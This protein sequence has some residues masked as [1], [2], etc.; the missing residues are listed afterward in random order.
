MKKVFGYIRVSTVKQSSGVSLQEQK[1]A[2]I[3]YASK[4]Q[5]E[6]IEW[7]EEQETAA[8][9]G[10]PQFTKMMK[11]IRSGK[12]MG[13]IIHK[14]DRGARNLKD[15]GV[16]GDLIDEGYEIHFAHESL[17]MDTRGGRLAADIQ[18]VIASDYIR[19]LREETQKGINGRLKQGLYPFRAPIGYI[20]NGGG[21]VKTIDSI[22][23]PIIKKAFLLYASNKYNLEKLCN[24]I[25]EF[26][27]TNEIGNRISITTMSKILNNPFYAGILKVNENTYQGVHEPLIS[28]STFNQVQNILTGKT[29][30]TGLKHDF[31]FRRYVKCEYCQYSLIGERQKGNVYYRCHS[32]SCQ[33]KTIREEILELEIHKI[34]NQVKLSKEEGQVLD[35]L[36]LKAQTNWTYIQSGIEESLNLQHSKAL[37][38]IDKLTDALLDSLIDKET[39]EQK[40][41]KILFEIQDINER[42]AKISGEKDNIFKKAKNYIELAKSLT[43]S[44]LNGNTEDKRDLLKIITSNFTINKKNLMFTIKSPFAEIANRYNLSECA[45]SREIP[46]IKFANPA[47]INDYVIDNTKHE[48]PIPANSQEN[49]SSNIPVDK[50]KLRESMQSL[51]DLIL[52]QVEKIEDLKSNSVL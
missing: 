27:L 22:K 20:N 48:A 47:I 41:E 12:S 52:S 7:F 16:L 10:R 35:D 43:K 24:E 13:V 5:L 33:I 36:L 8:K 44:Y 3:R 11:L 26:G 6:I 30:A 1:E 21:K 4:N 28:V 9:Q 42:R 32:K 31:L 23:G 51:L 34:I 18:A 49:D 25:Q 39:F 2:I 19:N 40:K 14:I 45:P 50:E 15:W 46:R 29:N 17:D 38:R 37:Q